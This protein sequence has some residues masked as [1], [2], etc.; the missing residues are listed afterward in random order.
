MSTE[1]PTPRSPRRGP[2]ARSAI[3]II[4]LITLIGGAVGFVVAITT[5]EKWMVTSKVLLQIGPETGGSRPS[6]VGSPAPLITG[7]PRRE[8]LQ[9][10]VEL[11]A[12]Q[13]LLRRAFQQLMKEDVDGALGP[14][15]K[16]WKVFLREIGE[17]LKLMPV[18]SRDER[19]LDTWADN[20]RIAVVP[21]STVLEIQCRSERP[22]AA[23]RLIEIMLEQYHADHVKAYSTKGVPEVIMRFLAA[24]ETALADAEKVL[25]SKRAELGVVDVIQETSLLLKRKSEAE[26]RQREIAGKLAGTR[27]RVTAL[28][29]QLDQTPAEQKLTAER[30][31]NPTHDELQLRLATA[32]QELTTALQQYQEDAPQVRTAREVVNLLTDLEKNAE[33]VRDSSS[34]VGRNTLHD[35]LRDHLLAAKAEEAALDAELGVWNSTVTEVSARITVIEAGRAAI[36]KAEIDVDESKKALAQANE[37]ARLARVE[38]ILD[39]NK[40]ANV[41]VV[42]PP[43]WLPTPLRTFGLATRLAITL[44]GF[45]VGLGLGTTFMLWRRSVALR[46]IAVVATGQTGAA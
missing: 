13:D 25:S 8:D 31:P 37:G 34:V 32:K 43:T 9:T 14:E 41:A 3:V 22:K 39:E 30:R 38:R 19:A 29:A 12:S 36:Q 18:R 45:I 17:G 15:P 28:A 4:A 46:P 10:E 1:S 21:S 7:N 5:N 27:V 6:M 35:S 11:L 33:P 42:I 16:R 24:R 40:I 44:A 20:L 23:T 2:T 26:T